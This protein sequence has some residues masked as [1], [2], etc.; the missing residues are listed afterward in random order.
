MIEG[1]K[2]KRVVILA[3]GIAGGK[4]AAGLRLLSLLRQAEIPTGGILAPRVMKGDETIGYSV[5]DLATNTTHPFAGLEPQDV[6][7]GRYFVSRESIARAQ[8]AVLGVCATCAVVFVDEIGRLELRG[9]GHAPA[10]HQLLRGDPVAVLL[11]RDELVGDVKETFGIKDPLVF[12]VEE[13][14]D[15]SMATPAGIGT[16]WQI[17]DDIRF[18]LL[19]TQ[20]DEGFPESRP[21]ALVHREGRTLWF[22]T[23]RASRKT[24]QIE[25]EPRVSVLFVDS[26]RF[27][28]AT[29]HGSASIVADRELGKSLW[30]EAWRDDW[31][32]GPSDPDYVLLR[33]DVVRGH[34]L[35]GATG[36]SGTVDL[37]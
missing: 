27:N 12:R 11:V 33:V 28:Y 22:A 15:R 17:V 3:G 25:C 18:P 8:K 32:E 10:V 13:A 36:E 31:P 19:V 23:S 34:Y 21:M 24:A 7:I 30:Q 1:R 29:L 2:P 14:H 37:A 26:D 5:I 6:Q 9:E 16:F 20:G 35:R 4:T